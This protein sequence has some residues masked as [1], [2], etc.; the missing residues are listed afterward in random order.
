MAA[1]FFIGAPDR[2]TPIPHGIILPC[3]T[4][5]TTPGGNPGVN[6]QFVETAV[7]SRRIEKLRLEEE[8]RDLQLVLL[9]NP[10]AGR[11]DSG[12]G[13]LRK[14]RMA[15]AC[16]NKGKR[17]G[18]RVHYLHL[19]HIKRIYLIFIY[20]KNQEDTLKPDQKL[21]LARVVTSIKNELGG[22]HEG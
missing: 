13:G 7:F 11:L 19:R 18:A 20:T 1:S 3:S 2:L 6:L 16:R 14:V 5:S 22:I 10:E 15:L 4:V 21:Q 8:L 9:K 17:G 12:T